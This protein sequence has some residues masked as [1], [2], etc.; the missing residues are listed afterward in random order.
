MC[1]A[2]LAGKLLAGS[3]RQTL[4]RGDPRQKPSKPSIEMD[5]L[6]PS[7]SSGSRLNDKKL[8][9]SRQQTVYDASVYVRQTEIA[10]LVA[11]GQFFVIKAQQVQ[12]RGLQVV[13]VDFVFHDAKA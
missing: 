1:Q 6:F 10:A 4:R 13:D 3:A 11:I 7:A 5:S 8:F 2:D 9:A 12:Q